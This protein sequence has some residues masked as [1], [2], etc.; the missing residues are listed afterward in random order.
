MAGAE[1]APF[2][3]HQSHYACSSCGGDD[4]DDD[5]DEDGDDSEGCFFFF[6]VYVSSLGGL[7]FKYHNCVAFDM[8]SVESSLCT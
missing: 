4:G 7:L 2:P 6:F 1:P 5:D 8:T 3:I